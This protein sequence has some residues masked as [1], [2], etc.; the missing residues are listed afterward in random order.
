MWEVSRF[1]NPKGR[2]IGVGATTEQRDD[3]VLL[4]QQFEAEGTY[5]DIQDA[6]HA[7]KHVACA[8]DAPY[9]SPAISVKLTGRAYLATLNPIVRTWYRIR[10]S[11]R[12]LCL[13]S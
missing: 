13:A 1:M 3:A 8:W 7:A 11:L 2:F 6:L 12:E 5:I 4:V 9:H 10:N